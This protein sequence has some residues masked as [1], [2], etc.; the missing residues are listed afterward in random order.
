[1]GE[2][3][4]ALPGVALRVDPNAAWSVPAALRAARELEP[5]GLEY[6]EDP[7]SGLEGM[8]RVRAATRTPL[9]TNMC[10]V[11][12]EELAPAVR[13]GAVDVV[14]A[15]VH[16]WGGIHATVAMRAVCQAFGLGVNLH[17]GGE[18]GLSTA[19]H[20]QVASALGLNDFAADSMYPL[21]ADDVVA[22]PVGL[23]EGALAVPSAPGLG[24][25]VDMDKLRHY[26]ARNA[27]EGDHTL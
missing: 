24:V 22:E 20:L 16:K 7:C 11:R 18:L 2:L 4:R 1:M 25:Q 27:E 9:C 12:L 14:H 21:L 15:D 23:R 8:A 5:L 3:R 6:L 17:S 10:V 13:M 26:A 19:C